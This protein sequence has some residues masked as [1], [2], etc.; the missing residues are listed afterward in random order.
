SHLGR[1]KG[2]P[3]PEFSLKAV[4]VALEK[5]LGEKVIF[6]DDDTVVGEK[7]KSDFQLLKNSDARVMLLQNTRFTPKEEENDPAFA[8]QLSAFGDIFVLDAFGCA[9][10]AHAST[11]GLA[12]Y[13]PAY[14]GFL[15][16]K[17]VKFLK[18]ALEE[19]ESPFTVVMG[20]SKVSDKI[21]LITNLMSKADNILIGGA[22]AQTFLKSRG[23]NVGISKI[24]ED[25]LELAGQILEQADEMGVNI[26]LP[27]DVTGS[28]AFSNET[29]K[30]LYTIDA[31][32]DDFMALDIG[33]KT[34]QNYAKI[35][36]KSKTVVFNG[37]M[38]V[39]EMANYEQGT[40][41]VI[42]AMA[43]CDG[44]TVIGGGDSASAVAQ[45]GYS[46]KMTHISTGGGASLELLEG[47]VLP[48][49]AILED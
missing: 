3:S 29:P 11:V 6:S 20:G 13:L 15:I 8:K 10:R 45:F 14:G 35:I 18:D 47:K 31:I 46:D 2:K 34:A 33:E 32:P 49:V 42:E 25:K 22:M 27:V 23:Y 40:K 39:F 17:E 36:L 30:A 38:G 43:D 19:P 7:A 9:H 48:G 44:V 37:P 21:T 4:A 12:D 41:K 28:S 5:M 1:P 26:Y 24:E 16:E